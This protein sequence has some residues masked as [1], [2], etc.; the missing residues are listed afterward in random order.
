MRKHTKTA[1][2]QHG[3]P[4]SNW[5]SNRAI[6]LLSLYRGYPDPPSDFFTGTQ[7]D[8]TLWLEMKGYITLEPIRISNK[9]REEVARMLNQ[10]VEETHARLV[11]GT[12][13]QWRGDAPNVFPDP[14]VS[15]VLSPPDNPMLK[16]LD[17]EK[18]YHPRSSEEKQACEALLNAGVIMGR[19]APVGIPMGAWGEMQYRLAVLG[20][21]L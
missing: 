14:P 6:L 3:A 10:A 17:K 8:D 7:V 2:I 5:T 13:G 4:V 20:R 11:Q 12:D 1:V 18:W 16:M 15:E 21:D 19:K 9:G